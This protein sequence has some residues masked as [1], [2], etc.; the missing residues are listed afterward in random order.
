MTQPA[1]GLRIISTIS[2]ATEIIS[3]LGLGQYQV[4]RSHECD[5]PPKILDLPIC[6]RPAI[7]VDGSSQDIDSLVKARVASA[8]S[9]YDVDSALIAHLQPTHIVT[10]TQCDVCAVRLDDV[11]KALAQEIG[12]HVHVVSCEAYDLGGVFAD[13]HRVAAACSV[14]ASGE[15]LVARLHGRMNCL[16][17]KAAAAER[18]PRVA[19]I[20]WLEPLMHSGNWI[21]E[22]VELANGENLFGEK[23]HHAPYF[24]FEEL[25]ASDP[26]VIVCFPCG[27]DL[28]RTKA[29]MHW[30]TEKPGWAGLTAVREK[31]VWV[32]DGNQYFN[33]PGPRIVESLEIMAAILH[34]ELFPMELKNFERFVI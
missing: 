12:F 30:L 10:Q 6:T 23:G 17:V 19:C 33:R 27:F 8:L 1:P 24:A 20:E 22:L 21:P 9:V 32:V 28:A 5:Y 7:S 3:A 15:N 26:D 2:S 25:A 4:G 16:R 29:E 14:P 31:Q 34:P 11:E 13:M 18:R